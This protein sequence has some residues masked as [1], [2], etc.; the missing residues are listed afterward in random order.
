MNN[1][2][3]AE[4]GGE[5]TKFSTPFRLKFFNGCVEKV[6]SLSFKVKKRFKGFRLSFQ[7]I[8]PSVSRVDINKGNVEPESYS[9]KDKRGA[10]EIGFNK[11]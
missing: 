10:L 1:A 9:G 8:N 5:G 11:L 6:F 4:K 3:F 2:M 7:E